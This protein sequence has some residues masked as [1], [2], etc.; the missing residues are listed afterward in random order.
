MTRI[1]LRPQVPPEWQTDAVLD[2]ASP[3]DGEKYTVLDT[4]KN[5]R[6]I[7]IACRCTWSVQATR[8][9]VFVTV[10]GIA[11][12][13]GVSSPASNTPYY[14]YVAWALEAGLIALGTSTAELRKSFLL[15]GRSVKVEVSVTGGTVSKLEARVKYAKWP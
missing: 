14:V 3:G 1:G 9:D 8:M 15:E 2:Q 7:T 4:K 13:G 12:S 6:V 5:V 10:D 11:L